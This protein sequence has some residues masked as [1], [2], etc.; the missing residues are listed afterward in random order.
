MAEH[1]G[2]WRLCFCRKLHQAIA[3]SGAYKAGTVEE[4]RRGAAAVNSNAHGTGAS[5]GGNTDQVRF[6]C[7][8]QAAPTKPC[9]LIANPPGDSRRAA[10]PHLAAH[11]PP[12]GRARIA[13]TCTAC[14]IT[15]QLARCQ[16]S[17]LPWAAVHLSSC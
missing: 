3:E 6:G 17:G 14:D 7:L 12:R 4:M 16:P 8:R 15:R 9:F 10:A 11:S 2:M 5:P 1:R 13:K